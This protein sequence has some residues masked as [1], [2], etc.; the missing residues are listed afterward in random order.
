MRADVREDRGDVLRHHKVTAIEIRICLRHPADRQR[1]ARA[2][3][4]RGL[5][6]GAGLFHER[7]HIVQN[8][9]AHIDFSHVLHQ[10]QQFFL[11]DHGICP[12]K[13]IIHMAVAE[14]VD[15]ALVVGVAHADAD[16]EAVKLGIGEHR[17]TGRTHR[18]LRGEDDKRVRQSI[19]LAV[20]RDLVLLHGLQQ[21]G[22]CL[23]GG[24]VDLICQQQIRH[25]R[26]GLI[27]KLVCL[28]VIDR[29]ADDVRRH[30]VRRKLHTACLQAKDLCKGHGCCGLADAGHVLHEN[31]AL[32]QN[33]H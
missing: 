11:V 13:G 14:N 17:R 16:E 9:V 31:V 6:M 12:V 24:T 30:G 26:A 23:A 4:E 22:L 20:H 8:G 10:S 29:E 5:R 19:R 3:A 15:A 1:A 33:C 7:G 28:F 2:D 32:R 21:R 27:D 18:V 25:D